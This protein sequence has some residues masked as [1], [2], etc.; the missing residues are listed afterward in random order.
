M[1]PSDQLTMKQKLG[2]AAAQLV[3][4]G[5]HV[6]L[7]TGSTAIWFIESLS[8]RCK[9]E[10]LKITAVA[11][12]E[13]SYQNALKRG[14]TVL[15]CDSDF[16]GLDLTV[17]GA[18]EFDA[19]KFL[20]KG[21]GGALLR[22]KIL[23]TASKEFVVIVDE[24]KKVPC[25]G[26][27]IL[28]IEVIPFGYGSTLSFLLKKNIK[29]TLRRTKDGKPFITDGGN[30]TFDLSCPSAMYEN[31]LQLHQDLIAIPGV[32]ETGLFLNLADRVLVC[33]ATGLIE[34]L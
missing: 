5:M 21:K 6:G 14:L 25:I 17:D 24:S 1:N 7:G 15:P 4:D 16:S 10:G 32:V 27:D 12:S 2:A 30:W 28:P 23:A 11:S 9:E 20:I 29:A 19:R 18:D 33:H 13:V 26:Q 22:E 34:M 8:Q 3:E 31:A